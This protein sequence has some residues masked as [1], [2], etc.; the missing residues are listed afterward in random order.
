MTLMPRAAHALHSFTSVGGWALNPKLWG[1]LVAFCKW[2]PQ[3]GLDSNRGVER[4][5]EV[6]PGVRTDRPSS[7]L[8]PSVG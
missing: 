3:E 4:L 5:G 1:V 8:T 7:V 2:K 6:C